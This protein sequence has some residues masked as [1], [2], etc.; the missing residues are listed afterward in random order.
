MID[1]DILKTTLKFE[2]IY[3]KHPKDPGGLTIFGISMAMWPQA[4][5]WRCVDLIK[6]VKELREEIKYKYDKEKFLQE[7]FEENPDIEGAIIRFYNN[8]FWKKMRGDT[9]V[10][11]SKPIARTVFDTGVNIGMTRAAR[12]LQIAINLVG[13]QSL[14]VDGIIGQKTISGLNATL[15]EDRKLSK[16]VLEKMI[17]NLIRSQ[18]GMH[19]IEWCSS[20]QRNIFRGLFLRVSV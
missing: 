6:R 10:K 5:I 11:S 7:W 1:R 19:Y 20:N 15:F 14:A 8:N 13:N 12:Y 9:L 3:S 16:P 18:R 4:E 17:L 2:G